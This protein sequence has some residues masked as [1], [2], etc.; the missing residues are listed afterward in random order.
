MTTPI[1]NDPSTA[2]PNSATT[3][4]PSPDEMNGLRT[5][6]YESE[7]T[8]HAEPR[9]GWIEQ[10]FPSWRIRHPVKLAALLRRKYGGDYT[11]EMRHNTYTLWAASRLESSEIDSC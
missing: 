11:V 3:E 2:V 4:S 5:R 10:S 1:T 7:A 9:D 8:G 6:S